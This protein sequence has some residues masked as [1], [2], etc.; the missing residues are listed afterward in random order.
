MTFAVAAHTRKISRRP[1]ICPTTGNI[2][3]LHKLGESGFDGAQ[4]LS[5]HLQEIRICTGRLFFLQK[6]LEPTDYY[7]CTASGQPC[8]VLK[9]S[10]H[11]VGFSFLVKK[12]EVKVVM[13]VSSFVD[14]ILNLHGHDLRLF[15]SCLSR[16]KHSLPQCNVPV[17]FNGMS[18]RLS[19][20]PSL[21]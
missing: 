2:L 18:G 19:G 17:V 13:L 11:C 4:K 12:C 3:I 9:K 7:Q 5:K 6:E 16:F 8:T 14:I 15:W 10:C 21:Y 20:V 1:C